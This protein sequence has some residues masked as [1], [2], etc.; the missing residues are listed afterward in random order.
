LQGRSAMAVPQI[1]LPGAQGVP[2]RSPRERVDDRGEGDAMRASPRRARTPTPRPDRGGAAAP[3]N[4]P[5]RSLARNARQEVAR[6]ARVGLARDA[7]APLAGSA[8]RDLTWPRQGEGVPRRRGRTERGRPHRSQRRS[9]GSHG[10]S[11]PL[12]QTPRAHR[13][14]RPRR[15]EGGRRRLVW[16]E[17]EPPPSR[18]A[19]AVAGKER[20]AGRAAPFRCSATPPARTAPA[21]P[22]TGG[23]KEATS[24]AFNGL[25]H[26][27]LTCGSRGKEPEEL[28]DPAT[29][30]ASQVHGRAAHFRA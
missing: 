8:L 14:L 19:G 18:V 28:L 12:R 29:L 17:A 26:P 21:A 16:T 20:E 11:P 22:P 5:E 10:A 24:R 30:R 7:G 23:R 2:A 3:T 1:S 9:A 25:R 13:P 27:G 6:A 15:G 4:P